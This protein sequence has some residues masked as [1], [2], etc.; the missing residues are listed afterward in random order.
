MSERDEARFARIDTVCLDLDGTLVDTVSGWHAAFAERW[1]ELLA[2]APA[3]DR[4]G[5]SAVAYD[6]YLRRYMHEAQEASGDGEWSDDFVREAFRRL[7]ALGGGP[8]DEAANAIADSY[9]T[10]ANAHMHLFPEVAEA[11]TVLGARA[12][13]GLISNGLVRDQEAK[14]EATAIAD[15]FDTIVISEAVDLVKP[16]PAIFAYALARLDT[17]PER[18]LYAG[19]NPEHDVD[20]ARAAGMLAVWVHRGDG[21]YGTAPN[22]DATVSDLGE[23]AALLRTD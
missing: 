6:D 12:R 18:A 17:R 21:F 13:L 2:I 22:A 16:D 10:G 23:L 14:I 5:S 19:D 9:I 8:R 4:I 7:V 1:P 20:G 15:W 11:L 3:L